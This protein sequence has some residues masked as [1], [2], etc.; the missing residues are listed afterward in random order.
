MECCRDGGCHLSK[1][2]LLR[3]GW[4]ALGHRC[5]NFRTFRCESAAVV[6]HYR[7]TIRCCVKRRVIS[8]CGTFYNSILSL[9]HTETAAT[10]PSHSPSRIYRL[11]HAL[12]ARHH[13]RPA[14]Y[15]SFGCW[16]LLSLAG[17]ERY[18]EATRIVGS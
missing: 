17:G 14:S 1:S 11:M 13:P 10:V 16:S 5:A 7:T 12:L 9:A 6:P 15:F 8:H 3:G 4:L 2:T 18:P